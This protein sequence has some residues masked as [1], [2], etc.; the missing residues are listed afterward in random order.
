MKWRIVSISAAIIAVLGGTAFFALQ[1]P[2]RPAAAQPATAAAV[3]T[4]PPA[5]VKDESVA[6]LTGMRDVLAA[7]RKT[8]VLLA[9]EKAMNANERA[10]ANQVGQGLFHE[11][12]ARVQ[13]LNDALTTLL[14]SP[15]P[16]RFA[17]LE[18]IL[19]FIE[20]GEGLFDAD[21]L[22]FREILTEMRRVAATDQ[23]LPAIK[24]HKR[25]SEDIDALVEIETQYD[26]ELKQIFGRFETRSIEIK[27]ERW[28]DYLTSLR[29]LYTREQINFRLQPAAKDRG[30]D[31]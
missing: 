20:S 29:K 3:K 26:K 13:Q 22:A 24:L 7:H 28:E 5:P 10:A 25:I 19:T 8:I 12:I 18:G 30:A 31:L 6:I 17:K 23:T 11:N 1:K 9:D 16:Q 14:K 15:D 2:G 4:A 27:R 21:R